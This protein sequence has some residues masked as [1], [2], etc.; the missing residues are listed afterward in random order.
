MID[1]RSD[2]VT[3]PTPVMRDAI[4]HAEVGDDVYGE[5][6]TVN[7]L[8]R[9]TAEILGKEDAVYMPTGTMANQVALRTHT[10]AGDEV[11]TDI[12]AHLFLLECGA[13]GALSGLIIRPL[14]GQ[15]GIFSASDVIQAIR[16]PHRFMP[17]TVL[18]PTKLLCVENTHNM[19]GGVIWPI[20]AIREVTEAAK[21]YGLATHLDG[22]RLWHASVATGISEAEYASGFN[23]V[24]V[25]FSKGLGAPIGSALAGSADFVRRARRFKQMFGGGFRQAGII[26]AGALY[27]LENHRER[28]AE[29][30]KKAQLFA[31]GLKQ[32]AS[33]DIDVALVQT[34]IIRFRILTMS[35]SE[36]VDRCYEMGLH[37]LPAGLDQIRAVTH[38]GISMEQVEEAL[39]IAEDVVGEH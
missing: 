39:S 20:E 26:A 29:D 2:T 31:A 25:C 36:F 27:A 24:T 6:P 4:A 23:S 21:K 14:T 15:N 19:A 37:M 3:K 7:A 38:L 11:L 13:A 5:D 22:A 17:S 35:S 1:L 30:H 12:N 8:E 18:P 34:N 10:E 32:I 28:L 9:R 16:I 33:I